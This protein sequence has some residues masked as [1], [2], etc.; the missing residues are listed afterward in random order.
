M[1][2]Q[3]PLQLGQRGK[4]QTTLYT[5]VLLAFLMLQLMSAELTWVS[6][7]SATHAA[8]VW[9]HVTVL[10]HVSLQVA[11]LGEGLVAHLALVRTHAL[12]GE[13]VCVQVAQ[14][15]KQLSTQVAP[16]WLDAAVPQDMRDQVVLGGVGLLAHAT[17]PSLLV[18]SHIHVVAVINMDVKTQL[19][20]AGH[21]ASRRSVTAAVT[22]SEVLFG[23]ERPRGE[24]H[25]GPRHEEGVW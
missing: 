11:G 24:V 14:L 16:M 5:Y 15:L 2:S 10:H 3:V 13:Q 4:V 17:L 18:T 12:V 20:S 8:A 23:V 7:A 21:P 22:G 25:D 1:G 6:E 9:L 19:L